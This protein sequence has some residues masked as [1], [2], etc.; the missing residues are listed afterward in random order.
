VFP[1]TVVQTCIVHLMRNPMSF[2]FWK[3][4]KAIAGALRSA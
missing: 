1:K 4:S 3:D 2:A